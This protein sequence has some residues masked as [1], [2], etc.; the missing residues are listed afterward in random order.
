MQSVAVVPHGNI[1]HDILLRLVTRLVVAPLH[2]LLF[3][4][5]EEALCHSV[6]PAISLTTHTANKVVGL[7]EARLDIS[8]YLMEYYNY[9]RP[10]TFNQRLAPAIA[11]EKPYPMSKIT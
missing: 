10:H 5:A 7:D 1:V 2:T 8:S 4:A 3:Q 9:Q 11:E 6:I